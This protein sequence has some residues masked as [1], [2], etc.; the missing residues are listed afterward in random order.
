MDSETLFKELNALYGEGNPEKIERFLLSKV[1]ESKSANTEDSL[2]LLIWAKSELGSLH[3]GQGRFTDSENDFLEAIDG[4]LTLPGEH[5]E[6]LAIS[7]NNLAGTY[8]MAQRNQDAL[9]TFQK[10]MAIYEELDYF[11]SYGYASVFNNLALVY[12]Q[13]GQMEPAI[14]YLLTAYQK[15]QE[16]GKLLPVAISQTNIAMMFNKIGER[17]RADELLRQTEEIFSTN[18]PGDYH[19][20]ALFAAKGSLQAQDNNPEAVQSFESAAAIIKRIYGESHE[21]QMMQR[22]IAYL[23]ERFGPGA[24]NAKS[25]SA[26]GR[27]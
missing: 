20:A 10:A 1:E 16:R 14:E 11:D 7:Y 2:N 24:E 6:E 4:L 8:R 3:R 5:R 19:Q 26:N 21:Y 15:L 23:N 25:D 27:N 18:F 17:E 13:M 12:E 22:N 9:R